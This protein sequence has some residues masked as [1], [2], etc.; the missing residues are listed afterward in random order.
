ML[1]REEVGWT[2]RQGLDAR[3]LVDKLC[4]AAVGDVRWEQ[5][6]APQSRPV[7]LQD[8]QD[9]HQR[10]VLEREKEDRTECPRSI[11]SANMAAGGK[12]DHFGTGRMTAGD[13]EI[14]GKGDRVVEERVVARLESREPLRGAKGRPALLCGS[15]RD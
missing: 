3:G 10:D 12:A 5:S 11:E 9:R 7:L 2:W 6:A 13:Q 15:R 1:E 14:I 4:E 8:G